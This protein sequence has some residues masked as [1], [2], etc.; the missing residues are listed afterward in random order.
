MALHLPP[1]AP[2]DVRE[3]RWKPKEGDCP[4]GS[5]VTVST[6]T[7]TVADDLEGE[8]VLITVTGGAAGVT[9][10]LA[11]SATV[12]EETITETIY[13]PVL[14]TAKALAITG[15]DI[16][17][18]VLDLVVGLDDT[19]TASETALALKKLSDM[20]ASWAEQ[21]ANMGV[22]LPITTSTVFLC[23][24]GEIEAIKSNLYLRVMPRFQRGWMPTPE[25]TMA[26]RRGL[27]QIKSA[28]LPEERAP[29]VYY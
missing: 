20:L 1:K 14:A 19:P 28:R 11:A 16:I 5:T 23:P 25:E 12:G 3:Y 29:S 7:A 13:I 8:Y 18:D 17:S 15:Q 4:S 9:Q 21:G 22:P 27:Q 10:I 24:D 26:A 2:S 6:G